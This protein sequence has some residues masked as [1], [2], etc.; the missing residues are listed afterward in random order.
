V[1]Q[2]KPS[3]AHT[4]IGALRAGGIE[5]AKGPLARMYEAFTAGLD[6]CLRAEIPA[7]PANR[8]R[9]TTF[10]VVCLAMSQSQLVRLGVAR[11]HTQSL[12]ASAEVL[13]EALRRE[14]S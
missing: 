10:A 3:R 2:R 1:F 7:A 9:S 8:R 13:I 12:R 6:A 14:R 4:L 5:S 11:S